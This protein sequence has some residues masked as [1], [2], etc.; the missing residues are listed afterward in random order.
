MEATILWDDFHALIRPLDHLP[1]AK[2]GRPPFPLEVMLIDTPCF[3][4]FA[5]ID[6]IS[7]RIPDETTILNF[8]HL[9]EDHTIGDQIFEAVRQTL[10][11]ALK[12]QGALL[13]E[14]TILDATIIHAP[15]S[16][17][18]KKRVRD[19]EMHSVAQG[20]QGFH[21]FAEGFACGMR[22]HIGAMRP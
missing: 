18:D 6:M 17:R 7:E 12:E 2:G 11:Q 14:G 13:Q 3:R 9:L 20:N 10:K 8:R 5:G 16:T 21:C 22:G 19:P 1:S 4:R 15:S